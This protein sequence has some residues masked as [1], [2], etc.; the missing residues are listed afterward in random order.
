MHAVTHTSKG[1]DLNTHQKMNWTPESEFDLILIS[2]SHF[3][4]VCMFTTHFP[5]R[6]WI[7]LWVCVCVR[8]LLLLLSFCFCWFPRT[9]TFALLALALNWL[10]LA[11][12]HSRAGGQNVTNIIDLDF[13]PI[14]HTLDSFLVAPIFRRSLVL[15]INRN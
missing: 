5:L 3:F 6:V 13:L 11:R 15:S 14:A 8:V 4:F 12:T 1:F 2:L 9:H 10:P 7:Y